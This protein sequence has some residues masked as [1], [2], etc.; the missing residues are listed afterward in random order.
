VLVADDAYDEGE[1]ISGVAP[2]V[3]VNAAGDVLVAWGRRPLVSQRR[4]PLY[5]RIRHAGRWRRPAQRVGDLLESGT[6]VAM[7]SDQ[8]RAVVA[9]WT[10]HADTGG[11]GSG[12]LAPPVYQVAAA[13]KTG[14]FGAANHLDAGAVGPGPVPGFPT[15]LPLTPNLFAAIAP[16]GRVR[17]AWTGADPDGPLVRVATLAGGK[18]MATQTLGRGIVA[19]VGT[20]GRD[21]A[22]ALWGNATRVFASTAL[23]G[24]PYAAVPELIDS[25][26]A[27]AAAAG[28]VAFD[29]RTH[30][31]FAV[32]EA[33]DPSAPGFVD[34][35][36]ARTAIRRP[37]TR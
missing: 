13:G 36:H 21:R 32:W 2:A 20:D 24:Q 30:R 7:L 6:V 33:G 35:W 28:N 1:F 8:N 25:G 14:R 16:S 26:P 18:L 23:A 31:V 37:L 5:A 22:V 3:A 15:F 12:P 9:W 17:L 27:F 34:A 11:A 10:Q 4:W 19:A 29:P